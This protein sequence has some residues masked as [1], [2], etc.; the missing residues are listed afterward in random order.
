MNICDYGCGQEAKYQFTNGKMC[1][2]EHY[3]KCPTHRNKRR[4]KG[5]PFHGKQHTIISKEK[6][7]NK[8][9]GRKKQKFQPLKDNRE[10][11]CKFGCGNL[12]K[13]VSINGEYYCSN[14][15]SSCPKIKQV[16]RNKNMGMKNSKRQKFKKIIV[17]NKE[18][19]EY[20]CGQRA[21][22]INKNGKLCCSEYIT[23]CP[24]RTTKYKIEDYKNKYLL[25]SRI[26]E[27][28]YNPEHPGEIQVHCKNNLCS[29]S[30]EQGGWFT[31][32]KTQ[33]YERC[34]SIEKF[35]LDYSYFY[36]SD[37]CKEICPLYRSRGVDPL[38]ERKEFY[39]IEEYDIFREYV[40]QRDN[41]KCQ[42]CEKKAEH[43]HH[44]RPQKLEP[45]FS[46]DPDLAWSVCKNCH[47]KKAHK[48]DC[49]TGKLAIKICP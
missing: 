44:E 12:A 5:N 17:E 43:V 29:N 16:N 40:L 3:L 48:D 6:I 33:L 36:C 11:Y 8:L 41:F 31:P 13:F 22:F 38:K 14:S 2:E 34:R 47:Y 30:K 15:P 28:R 24:N 10:V 49:S 27:M 32:S 45:F 20:G 42:Y 25:F 46:L 23:Q 26:E 37:D 19:C 4:E 35:N 18:L 21:Q 7:K 39:T 9:I 1:C